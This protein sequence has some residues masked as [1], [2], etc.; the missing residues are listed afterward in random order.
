MSLAFLGCS[1]E[2]DAPY[3]AAAAAASETAVGSAQQALIGG[4]ATFARPAVGWLESDGLG[5]TATLVDSSFILTAA[6]CVQYRQ[7]DIWGTFS[8]WNTA[9]Q[10]LSTVNVDTANSFGIEPGNGDFAFLHLTDPIPSSTVTPVPLGPRPQAGQQV[11]AFGFGCTN[12][13]TQEGAHIKRYGSYAYGNSAMI[14]P[15]D[16]GGPRVHGSHNGTGSIWAVNSG[17]HPRDGGDILAD[18]TQDGPS[19]LTGARKFAGSVENESS[20]LDF[21]SWAT[22]PGVKAVSG[23][24]N[25]DAYADIA[26]VGGSG[27]ASVPVAFGNG[28]GHF[29]ETN[30]WLINFP[31]WATAARSVVG[32]DFDGD[33]D[34]DI[35]LLGGAGWTTIPVAF[36]SRNGRF[37]RTNT[38]VSQFPALSRAG[39]QAA[40]G[41]FDG[42]GDADI[43]LAGGQ[44]STGESWTT[45]PVAFSNRAGGFS[46]TN[47]SVPGFAN[48]AWFSRLIAGDFD[49]DGDADLVAAGN[50]RATHFAL[51]DRT[52]RFNHAQSP[53]RTFSGNSI[54]ASF[55]LAGKVDWGS[56]ADLILLGSTRWSSIYSSILRAPYTP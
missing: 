25:G 21:A 7:G 30:H 33:G 27:W 15:G 48:V 10:L 23:D 34:T 20:S 24:F 8:V 17:W 19:A 18:T 43:A 52:G 41:D 26:L 49:G 12:R 6:H 55:I 5:C 47:H 9:G 2:V 51:S 32:G 13:D 46:V 28:H 29:T 37:T 45:I 38:A 31:S 14:C 50:A 16:S 53:L 36:S 42:D 54:Y 1:A 44:K 39:A 35:A 40:V 56:Q 22:A 4:T 11:T 3:D